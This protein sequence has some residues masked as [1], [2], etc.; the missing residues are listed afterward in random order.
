LWSRL[1]AN[2]GFETPRFFE[3]RSSADEDFTARIALTDLEPSTTYHY[4]VRFD[5][6][7]RLERLVA[8]AN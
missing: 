6:S 2:A 7:P 8:T 1:D 3:G 4:R 5:D